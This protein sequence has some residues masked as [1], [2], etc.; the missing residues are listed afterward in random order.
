MLEF[1]HKIRVRYVECDQMQFVHHSVYAIY[2]EEARTEVLRKI[3]MVYSIME[4]EGII[5]PVRHM[6]IKYH[7]AAKYDDVLRIVVR[8]KSMPLL[9]CEL[10][11]EVYNQEEKLLTSAD[12]Q[13]FF[14]NKL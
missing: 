4:Q 2:F 13:L 14:A 6:N 8:M 5:M 3:G 11:Y 9:K 12:M 7:Y 10:E 1:E